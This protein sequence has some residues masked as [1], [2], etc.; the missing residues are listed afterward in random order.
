[1]TGCRSCQSSS[2][3]YYKKFPGGAVKFQ[4]ISSISRGDFKFQ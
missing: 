4:E 3:I 1:M 2:S